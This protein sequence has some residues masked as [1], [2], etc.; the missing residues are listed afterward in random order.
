LAVTPSGGTL[1]ASAETI[2]LAP[3]AT[4]A[5]V[6]ITPV[7]DVAVESTET[8]TLSLA[9]GTGYTTTSPTSASGSI[10]DNDVAAVVSV[11][12]T[13]ASGAEAGSDPITFTITRSGSTA[14]AIVVNLGWAGT[15]T[16][17]TDYAVTVTGGTLSADG[18]TLTLAAGATSATVKVTPVDD[19]AVESAET[20][21]LTLAGGA[22][23]TLGSPSSASGSIA[24]NDVNAVE[25]VAATDGS[26][27]E[28]GSDPI[29][30]TVT[31]TASLTNAI[32]IV[33]TWG[34]TA[35]LGSDYAVSA[36]GGT[37]G[38]NATTITRAAGVASATITVTPVDDTSV[39]SAETVTLALGAGTGY[40]LGSPS[41]ASSSIADND[42]R[43]ISVA[44]ATVT[45][46]D[47]KTSNVTVVVTLSQAST[48][49]VTVV[50]K[51]VGGT[52][53]AG[54]DFTSKT[55]TLTFNA[56]VTSVSFTVAIIGDRK[57]EPT[58][59]FTVVLSSPTGAQLGRATGTVT[60]LDN[61]GAQMASAAPAEATSVR[62]LTAAELDPVVARAKA[63]WLALMPGAD[64]A[65]IS[66]SIADLPN[67]FLAQTIGRS[68][69]IDATAGGWSWSRMD[70]HTVVLH[71]LGR[72]LGLT[73]DDAAR[74]PIMTLT[75]DP[76]ERRSLGEPLGGGVP[77]RVAPRLD[78]RLLLRPAATPAFVVRP[79]LAA[80]VSSR[81]VAATV[82]P[83][84]F[85]A[86]HRTA[87]GLFRQLAQRVGAFSVA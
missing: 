31:R 42:V 80:R 63:E 9:S 5:T 7:D 43:T 45:E 59:T 1:G 71:E 77:D 38:T 22:G 21:S 37:L 12:A 48:S 17:G 15:A 78:L 6:T 18:L 79:A 54:S 52:A 47:S 35:S 46:V 3:G 62:P 36:S 27:A 49:T 23:Y 32:T 39:E 19:A 84:A 25:T 13:D 44:D 28:A 74:F 87:T 64:L 24:D 40:T 55:S 30:F 66:F 70:L 26:G 60:I 61:D 41:S 29:R 10:V 51:T 85:R 8:V 67:L 68:V 20:V 75:L 58:E 53:V 4:S 14:N 86:V 65:G 33:L 82:H 50:A 76:G 16:R 69:T 83:R 2:T 57:A 81:D 34:G 72:V 56:G 11:A 73:E